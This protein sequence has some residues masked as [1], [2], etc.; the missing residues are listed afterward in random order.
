M[1]RRTKVARHPGVYY[2]D[3]G[4]K[5]RYEI[6]FLD[7]HGVRR[8]LTVDGNLDAA[9]AALAERKR[10]K[11]E[12]ERVAPEKVRLRQF[13]EAWLQ[14]QTRLRPR[15]RDLYA[16]QLRNHVYPRLGRLWLHDVREDDLKGLITGMENQGYSG[17]TI[18]GVLTPLGRVL[19]SA[20]R[21]RYLPSN[22][23]SRLEQSERP[24]VERRE[25]RCLNSDEIAKLL[26]HAD[27]THLPLIATSVF[28]GLRQGEALG[29]TWADVDLDAGIVKVRKQ[30]DRGGERVPPKTPKAVRD[31]EM[32]PA[33]VKLLRDQ[34]ERAFAA[35]R[36]R[37]TDY[38]FASRVGTPLHYRNVSKRGLEPAAEAAGLIPT[39]AERKAAKDTAKKAGKKQPTGTGLRWH[40]LRHTFA[41][42]L[43]AQGANVLYVSRML[44]HSSATVTLDVYGHLFD[45]AEHGERMR[46]GLEAAYGNALETTGGERRRTGDVVELSIPRNGA[47]ATAGGD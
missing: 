10:R 39:S 46:A 29:L 31:V 11:R 2:R 41:S 13:A 34:K 37:P 30:L 18:K 12:G 32:F 16:A 36:A 26:A 14:S 38:V 23:L 42:I 47:A 44:G 19:S 1:S 24:D 6:T 45:R 27:E 40:D 35:G 20:V 9:D 4:G 7:E 3:A 33:L 8:W 21:G 17:Y 28:T 43:I 15:T 22:P 25:M 5:R